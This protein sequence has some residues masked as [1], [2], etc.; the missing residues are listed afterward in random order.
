MSKQT[1]VVDDEEEEIEVQIEEGELV[2]PLYLALRLEQTR[3][4]N[5]ILK[6]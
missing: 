6:Y 2:T 5:I 4:I 1:E 3:S